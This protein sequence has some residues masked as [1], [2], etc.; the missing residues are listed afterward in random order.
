MLGGFSERAREVSLLLRNPVC[1]FVLVAGPDLQQA[2]SAESFWER[3]QAEGIQ[4][5][6]L[7]LNRVHAWPG[8][9]EAPADD[10]AEAERAVDWLSR[11]IAAR[12]PERRRDRQRARRSSP[13]RARRPRSRAATR[14]CANG[15]RS[16]L[17]LEPEAVRAVPLFSED[18]HE[19]EA[20]ARMASADLRRARAWLSRARRALDHLVRAAQELALALAAGAHALG[21]NARTLERVRAA[22]RAEEKRWA[23]RAAHDPAAERVREIVAALADVLEPRAP[24]S[25]AHGEFDRPRKRWDTRGPWRS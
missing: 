15:S 7:V 13:P 21:A 19:L 16:A 23:D 25:G 1:G 6:G 11:A 9:G 4:L 8:R 24:T 3:L 18:V 17:P 20:L 5:V 22:L 12:A 2:K 10:A 14:A